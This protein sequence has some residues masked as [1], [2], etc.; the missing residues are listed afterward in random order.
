M[1]ER[2]VRS[3]SQEEEGEEELGLGKA[4]GRRWRMPSPLPGGEESE[5]LSMKGAC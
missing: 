4:S 1:L 5:G 3:G 2:H